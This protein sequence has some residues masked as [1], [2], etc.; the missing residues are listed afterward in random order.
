M[1]SGVT[2]IFLRT[3]TDVHVSIDIV[4]KIKNFVPYKP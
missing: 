2:S 1:S 3:I 4:E